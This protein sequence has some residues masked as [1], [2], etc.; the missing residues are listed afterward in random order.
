VGL[1]L[2]AASVT[3]IVLSLK[4]Q[5]YKATTTV[6]APSAAATGAVDTPASVG[7][8]VANYQAALG[9]LAVAQQVARQTGASVGDAQNGVAAVQVGAS[10]DVEVSYTTTDRHRAGPVV[11]AAARAA[12]GV[13][14]QPEVVIAEQAATAAQTGLDRAKTAYNQVRDRADAL[15]G[16]GIAALAIDQYRSKLSELSQLRVSQVSAQVGDLTASRSSQSSFFGG[17]GSGLQATIDS[18]EQELTA[19]AP[20]AIASERVQDDLNSS[21]NE[22]TEARRRAQAAEA[23]VIGSRTVPDPAPPT[24]VAVSRIATILKGVVVVLVIGMLVALAVVVVPFVVGLPARIRRE[25][26][27]AGTVLTPA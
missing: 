18:R 12:F 14:E 4:P 8:Y 26:S 24:V 1:T 27:A 2:I 15:T 13:V 10:S 22:L 11:V 16:Q 7:Q 5:Q 3:S 19:L 20:A 9:T 6:T 25:Q 17:K 23:R 21:L